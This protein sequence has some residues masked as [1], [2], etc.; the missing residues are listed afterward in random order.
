MIRRVEEDED[1]R[2]KGGMGEEDMDY[3][4]SKKENRRKEGRR[5]RKERVG[6][7]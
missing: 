3:G 7:S 4:W 1:R 6:G 5:G 2:V